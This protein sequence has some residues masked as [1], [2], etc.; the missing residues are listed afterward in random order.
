MGEFLY[1]WAGYNRGLE[2]DWERTRLIVATQI[3]S[4]SKDKVSVTDV[5]R[6]TGDDERDEELNDLKKNYKPDE[7]TLGWLKRQGIIQK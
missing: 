7:E 4:H 2:R 1:W 3:N 6:L 5:I